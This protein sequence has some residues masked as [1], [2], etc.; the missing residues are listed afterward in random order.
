MALRNILIPELEANAYTSISL[1][2]KYDNWKKLKNDPTRKSE[3]VQYQNLLLDP[4]S[5]SISKDDNIDMWSFLTATSDER[6]QKALFVATYVPL[7]LYDYDKFLMITLRDGYDAP[8]NRVL[9]KLKNNKADISY[10]EFARNLKKT[11]FLLIRK[12]KYD[13]FKDLLDH[14]VDPNTKIEDKS[15]KIGDATLLLEAT[16]DVG[17][18]IHNDREHP[19]YIKFIKLLLDYGAKVDPLSIESAKRLKNIEILMFLL[20]SKLQ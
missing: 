5:W 11:L 3:Y 12:D 1:Q 19:E 18:H 15:G 14:G 9:Y 2:E 8:Y 13:W 17:K 10:E 6:K 20:S 16:R 4:L 7:R